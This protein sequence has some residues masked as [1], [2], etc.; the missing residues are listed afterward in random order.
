MN[1]SLKFGSESF[2]YEFLGLDDY[3]CSYLSDQISPT[4]TTA[5]IF[6]GM[7]SLAPIVFNSSHGKTLVDALYDQ[8]KIT[9]KLFAVSFF[10]GDSFIQF[11]EYDNNYVDESLIFVPNEFSNVWG[12][13]MTSYQIEGNYKTTT[14][15]KGYLTSSQFTYF[16]NAT[17]HQLINDLRKYSCNFEAGEVQCAC[18]MSMTSLP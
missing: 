8:G 7:L 16:P 11:G 6:G 3:N 5:L 15:I 14:N 4:N 2:N 12:F 13:N 17:M 18:D 10:D 1:T 9:Q